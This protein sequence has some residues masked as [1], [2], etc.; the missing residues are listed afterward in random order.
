MILTN[1]FS[2]IVYESISPSQMQSEQQ[3]LEHLLFPLPS[4]ITTKFPPSMVVFENGHFQYRNKYSF[5]DELVA[6]YSQDEAVAAWRKWRVAMNEKIE[7]FYAKRD[8]K[9]PPLFADYFQLESV[10]PVFRPQDTSRGTAYLQ[11]TR[12]PMYYEL[13]FRISLPTLRPEP[14]DRAWQDFSAE[15]A[16]EGKT[17][18][19][20]F[21]SVFV[22]NF[23]ETDL[24]NLI[25]PFANGILQGEGMKVFMGINKNVIG[26]DY[27]HLR[28]NGRRSNSELY[29]PYD[30]PAAKEIAPL[31]QNDLM[32]ASTQNN[33]NAN[34]RTSAPNTLAAS[35]P[36]TH[37]NAQMEMK[38]SAMVMRRTAN[39]LVAP[40]WMGLQG[41]MA[42]CREA[43]EKGGIDN[44]AFQSGEIPPSG[45]FVAVDKNSVLG[46]GN[47]N[48]LY[49]EGVKWADFKERIE[50]I[51]NIEPAIK[52]TISCA[53]KAYERK[54]NNK[55]EGG[56]EKY[57]IPIVPIVT[58]P[59]DKNYS[60]W[61]IKISGNIPKDVTEMKNEPYSYG[62]F[63]IDII[64]NFKSAIVLRFEDM[65]IKTEDKN[66]P[67]E[68]KPEDITLGVVRYEDRCKTK[69]QRSF[70]FH[71]RLMEKKEGKY[72][73]SDLYFAHLL[74]HELTETDSLI[75]GGYQYAY[76][77][78]DHKAAWLKDL[79]VMKS[80]FNIIFDIAY[81]YEVKLSAS[82]LSFASN[83]KNSYGYILYQSNGSITYTD[84]DLPILKLN[85][86]I[87]T[88]MILYIADKST[89]NYEDVAFFYFPSGAITETFSDSQVYLIDDKFA[90]IRSYPENTILPPRT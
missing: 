33:T 53:E 29:Q 25:K 68:V 77:N 70:A 88:L 11:K 9:I 22:Q 89:G 19:I 86:Y 28:L 7:T 82:N 31:A 66:K 73:V 79:Q 62:K 5:S 64:N 56:Y 59:S 37:T 3:T 12:Y 4:I 75:R 16:A 50:K 45:L 6:A 39:N 13:N 47:V 48:P 15:L 10:V 20:D 8:F 81:A 35:A 78:R 74:V 2:A 14:F 65:K 84:S 30:F 40:L 83:D 52:L 51:I 80:L 57:Q 41:V 21:A 27:F 76:H 72:K 24:R 71:S 42:A 32:Q 38:L 46:N 44:K 36:L 1:Y 87:D 18:V 60:A 58:F 17:D 34:A 23:L 55:Q 61:K 69:N 63:L 85:T 43:V 26:L 67:E 90:G 49:F 54:V